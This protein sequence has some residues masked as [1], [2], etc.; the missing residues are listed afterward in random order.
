MKDED[1]ESIDN[2]G[3]VTPQSLSNYVYI[4]I[5]RLPSYERPHQDPIIIT[6]GSAKIILASYPNRVFA[7]SCINCVYLTN[8]HY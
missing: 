4:A 7:F 1:N 5:K 6:E 2:E 8:R 3:N